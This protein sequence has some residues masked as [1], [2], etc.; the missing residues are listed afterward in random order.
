MLDE[1]L[2]RPVSHRCPPCQHRHRQPVEERATELALRDRHLRYHPCDLVR[3]RHPS[4]R[5]AWQ[6][7]C[8]GAWQQLK[9]KVDLLR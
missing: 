2:E 3:L 9:A 1:R 8:A 7:R 4:H 6:E 5:P